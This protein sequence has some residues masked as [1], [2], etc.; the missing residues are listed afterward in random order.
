MLE[1]QPPG[2]AGGMDAPEAVAGVPPDAEPAVC[3]TCDLVGVLCQSRSH[4]IAC[5]ER[6]RCGSTLGQVGFGC[7]GRLHLANLVAV[8]YPPFAASPSL[9]LRR[10]GGRPG[11]ALGGGS[12]RGR[13][14]DDRRGAHGGGEVVMGGA[15]LCREPERVV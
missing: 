14:P 6:A 15:A 8:C 2:S 4:R 11:D 3:L 12:R 13:R 7:A 5:N 10:S 1:R 9:A